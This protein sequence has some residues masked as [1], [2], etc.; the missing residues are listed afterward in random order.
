MH[1]QEQACG[2]T[3]ERS[4]VDPPRQRRCN[5]GHLFEWLES[6]YLKLSTG[7]KHIF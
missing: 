6:H 3:L 7:E 1:V 4:D 5:L 2:L